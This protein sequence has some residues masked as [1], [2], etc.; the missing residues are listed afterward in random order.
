MGAFFLVFALAVKPRPT[1]EPEGTSALDDL[2]E[3]RARLGAA[4]EGLE[5]PD[6][7]A[8]GQAAR[9]VVRIARDEVPAAVGGE[10]GEALAKQADELAALAG[11]AAAPDGPFAQKA[12]A[13]LSS[14]D[15]CLEGRAG[16]PAV[17]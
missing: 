5:A 7:G 16:D 6:A 3:L 12:R 14:V 1:G 9:E 4:V 10:E 17:R 2:P 15:A 13:L 8:R 11:E